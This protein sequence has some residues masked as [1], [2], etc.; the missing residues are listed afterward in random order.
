MIKRRQFHSGQSL[1]EI[2]VALGIIVVVL[3]GVSDLITRSLSLASFQASKNE[4]TNIAQD[5]LSYLKHEKELEPTAFFLR[6][7]V[8]NGIGDCDN[9]INFDTEKFVCKLQF[10]YLYDGPTRLDAIIA[11]AVVTWKNGDKEIVTKLS[12]T[13][14]KPIK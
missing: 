2:V 9:S 8:Q 5:Q 14:V 7:D 4:A 12:Q 10:E 3:V 1:I 13:L 6:Q 11:S